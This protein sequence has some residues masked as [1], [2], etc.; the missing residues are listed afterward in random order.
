MFHFQSLLEKQPRHYDALQ[1]LISLLKR[2]GRLSDAPKFLRMAERSSPKAV[3]ENGFKF[4]KVGSL[5]ALLTVIAQE[6]DVLDAA[7]SLR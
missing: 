5:H 2:A 7:G 6:I 4:C 3:H 1:R